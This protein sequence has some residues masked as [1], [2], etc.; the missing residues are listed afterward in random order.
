VTAALG[1]AAGGR[2]DAATLETATAGA[3]KRA[4]AAHDAATA[5]LGGLKP[6]RPVAE[7]EALLVAAKP[8]CRV[9]VQLGSRRTACSPPMAL[10]AELGRAK[11]RA[12]LEAKAERA[13]AELA[14][15][16]SVRQ[17]NSDAVAIAGYLTALG[18]QVDVDRVNRF[19]TLLTVL[20]VECGGGLALALA[21][22]LSGPA[23]TPTEASPDGLDTEAPTARTLPAATTDALPATGHPQTPPARAP[24]TL[25]VRPERTRP[26]T[27]VRPSRVITWLEQ[28]GGRAETSMRRLA[29]AIGRSPSGV[30]EELRRLV[31][32]GRVTASSGPRGT[33]LALATKAH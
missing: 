8:Q 22:A 9:I 30:H 4:Q 28:H 25:S 32:C 11:R 15:L 17:A 6:S 31:A 1:S 5:E 23:W 13:A 19:L 27:V 26:V 29:N 20:V 16:R 14:K 3:R 7:L 10:M 18:I 24:D 2:A 33:V 12:E 21:V